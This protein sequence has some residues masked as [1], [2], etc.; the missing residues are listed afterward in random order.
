VIN[1][2]VLE[3]RGMII[4]L[5]FQKKIDT[6]NNKEVR[7]HLALTVERFTL[8]DPSF[9]VVTQAGSRASKGRI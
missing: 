8:T 6:E 5:H 4:I 2:E 9:E 3:Q 7:T 1:I